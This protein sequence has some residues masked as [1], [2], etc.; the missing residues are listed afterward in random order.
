MTVNPFLDDSWG[1]DPELGP[2]TPQPPV[3]AEPVFSA[4]PQENL[5]MGTAG[6][7]DA[8]VSMWGDPQHVAPSTP[9]T[10]HAGNTPTDP[11]AYDNLTPVPATEP[12]SP[13]HM[14]PP[15]SVSVEENVETLTVSGVTVQLPPRIMSGFRAMLARLMDDDCSEV[16]A[17]GPSEV[18]IKV[19]GQ[20]YCDQHAVFESVDDY[21][22]AINALLAF[23]Q[24]ADRVDGETVLIE[25]QIEIESTTPGDPPMLGRVHLLAPPLVPVAKLTVAKK[26]RWSLTL[27]SMTESG[28]M[29]SG[30]ASFLR[31]VAKSRLTFVIAGPTGSGKT[32]LLQAMCRHFD[33]A[34]RIIVVEDT[35]ELRLIHGDC[36]H[37]TATQPR[38]GRPNDLIVEMDWLVRSANRMR[39]DRILVGEVR[40][41]EMAEWLI[42]ANSGADGSALTL[43]ADSPR[44]ALDKMLFLATKSNTAPSEITLRREIAATVD[45]IVQTGFVDGR[46]MVTGIEEVSTVVRDNHVIGTTELVEF[47]R[48]SAT[49]VV[50]NP[51]SDDLVYRM[52]HCGIAIDPAWYPQGK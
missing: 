34:E 24:T 49:H 30:M 13:M 38:P 52:R 15:E 26:A 25:G 5:D 51:P 8:E 31:A 40:G 50:R 46:H 36:V 14:E 22:R 19:R 2:V 18:L 33:L 42:A 41:A 10:P 45:L 9:A 23:V 1:D 17:N 29:T 12:P 44:R 21:H 16:I 11:V 35:P 7:V 20:R 28:A 27:E 43:H 47:D 4:P 6:G 37:L 32:T 3:N 39:M 48:A